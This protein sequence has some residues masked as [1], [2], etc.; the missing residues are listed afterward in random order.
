MHENAYSGG[1]GK[2]IRAHVV[3]G[4]RTHDA[5]V[6]KRMQERTLIVVRKP[7][8]RDIGISASGLALLGWRR[9]VEDGVVL[10]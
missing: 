7:W 1:K 2:S 5:A 4:A 10:E 6:T 8:E 3:T 9:S